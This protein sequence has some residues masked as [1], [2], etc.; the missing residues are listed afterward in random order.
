MI[1]PKAG[2]TH[3]NFIR[4]YTVANFYTTSTNSGSMPGIFN[5]TVTLTVKVLQ[6]LKHVALTEELKYVDIR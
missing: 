3:N 4:F 6:S 2:T 1:T 5:M